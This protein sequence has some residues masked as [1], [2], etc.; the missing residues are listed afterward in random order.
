M[1][2]IELFEDADAGAT[3]AA[4]I[5]SVAKPMGGLIR[6][7]MPVSEDIA[8]YDL[9]K[10]YAEFNNAY[11]DGALPKI[12][13]SFSNRLK[14]SSGQ[15]IGKWK[16]K[17]RNLVDMSTVE[18]RIA[19]ALQK[20]EEKLD[21]ILLHEMIHV[22]FF[23][24]GMPQ[25]DHGKNFLEK[26]KYISSI[27]GKDIPLRDTFDNTEEL[28]DHIKDKEYGVIWIMLYDKKQ[29]GLMSPRL[30]DYNTHPFELNSICSWLHKT[31]LWNSTVTEVAAG[32]VKSRELTK[33]AMN[34][35]V[36]RDY[37]K[38]KS[39]RSLPQGSEQAFNDFLQN[40]NIVFRQTKEEAKA[41]FK[42]EKEEELTEDATCGATGAANIASTT[43]YGTTPS[44]F[45]YVAPTKKKKKK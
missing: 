40:G 9:D 22:Y 30:L 15:A 39:V 24:I 20:S 45:G 35:P 14:N 1:L 34:Y 7:P 38:A 5:G 41:Q 33:L 44:L 13:L 23:T 16:D 12:K 28:A 17:A 29:F 27:S 26:L 32:T 37:R 42:K 43:S 10:K 8:S 11:F 6:R 4:N 25:E 19:G 36:A 18:I 21:G 31:V 3:S 2:L